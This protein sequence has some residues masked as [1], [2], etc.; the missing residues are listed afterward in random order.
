M[1]RYDEVREQ[2]KKI[3]LKIYPFDAF[4]LCVPV[5]M[6]NLRPERGKMQKIIEKNC[7]VFPFCVS[8]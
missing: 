4:C 5:R 1:Q 6:P 7:N 2:P 3:L 8:I